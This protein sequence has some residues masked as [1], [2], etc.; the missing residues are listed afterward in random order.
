MP[1]VPRPSATGAGRRE[2][3]GAG[4]QTGAPLQLG[5]IRGL[6]P[7]LSPRPR[8]RS[9]GRPPPGRPCRT[10]FSDHNGTRPG[11]GDTETTGNCPTTWSER[12]HLYILT[13]S[14]NVKVQ[15]AGTQLTG[16]FTAGSTCLRRDHKSTTLNPKEAGREEQI[17]A[18][19]EEGQVQRY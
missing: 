8:G 1:K 12:T 19:Q 14:K 2:P 11:A 6:L 15:R 5:R 17:K 4:V 13:W 3:P 7:A 9:R 16:T 10:V 18:K